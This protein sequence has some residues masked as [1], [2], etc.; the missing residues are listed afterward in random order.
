MTELA[1]TSDAGV[2]TISLAKKAAAQPK[3]VK[4]AVAGSQAKTVDEAA[5]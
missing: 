1:A 4:I 5:V 2:L 3:Q